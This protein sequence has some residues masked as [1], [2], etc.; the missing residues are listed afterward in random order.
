MVVVD[1]LS[2][3]ANIIPTTS[4]IM[5]A[6]VAWLFW[7]HVWKIHGLPKEVISN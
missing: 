6:G 3:Q 1:W 7:D 5:V 2:K 4:D